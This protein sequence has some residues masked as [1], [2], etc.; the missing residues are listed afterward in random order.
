MVVEDFCVVVDD[1]SECFEF[2]VV[3]IALG[4]GGFLFRFGC[5]FHRWVFYGEGKRMSRI[6][7]KKDFQ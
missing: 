2:D 4:D 5:W 3:F 7:L 6:I 1:C